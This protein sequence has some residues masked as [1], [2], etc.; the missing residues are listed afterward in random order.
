M[1]M[2]GISCWATERKF[3]H[4]FSYL[5]N[6][7][8]FPFTDKSTVQ[9]NANESSAGAIVASL[10]VLIVIGS[11]LGWFL[12][13]YRNPHTNSG[14][15]LIKVNEAFKILYIFENAKYDELFGCK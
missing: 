9:N 6:F 3:Y 12:Y 15:L 8:I 1:A 14:Q 2:T 7:N 11:I 10:T 13:A 4:T 5:F